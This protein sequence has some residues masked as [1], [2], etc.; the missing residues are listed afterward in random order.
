MHTQIL[1]EIEEH[2]VGAGFVSEGFGI[3]DRSKF[4]GLNHVDVKVLKLTQPSYKRYF[5]MAILK[6]VYHPPLI[7]EFKK[8]VIEQ[9]KLKQE[10]RFG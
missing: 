5:Y 3:N 1:C 8:Y 2:L 4:D 6:D 7:E 9:S 10:Y